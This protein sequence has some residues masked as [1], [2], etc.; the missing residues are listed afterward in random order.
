[1]ML[2]IIVAHTLED[3]R[4]VSVCKQFEKA[5]TLFGL[6][7]YIKKTV[8]LYQ[9][10][11][12]QTSIDPHVEIYDMPLKSVKNFTYLGSTVAS[13]TINVEINNHIQTASGAF[14]GM[15][16]HVWS[17]YG[18]SVSTKCKVYKAIVLPTLPYSAET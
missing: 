6:T 9:P 11:P 18:I 14:G 7:I 3:I 8:M 2:L 13:D 1:M 5:A 17:Q 4:E 16:K 10:P 15:W 12:S